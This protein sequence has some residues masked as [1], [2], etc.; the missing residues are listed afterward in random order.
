MANSSNNQDSSGD[1]H[2]ADNHDA[3][4]T[5]QFMR[6]LAQN[7]RRLAAYVLALVPHWADADEIVQETKIRLWQ[8]FG[9]Y[10]P[11][12]SFA[13]WACAIAKFQ[14][15]TYRK[16][17]GR[18]RA[19]FSDEF[20]GAVAE[21][22]ASVGNVT[23]REAALADCLEKLSPN[24]RDIVRRYYAGQSHIDDLAR[25]LSRRRRRSTRRSRRR[26]NFCTT[27]CSGRARC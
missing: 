8:Q 13:A 2:D 22:I 18:E 11:D 14:V 6:L 1:R 4:S 15:M 25:E 21:Q 10:R 7:E 19:R 26:G 24:N 3:D 9:D 16:R 12:E 27:A 20:A 17:M 23:A 5:V